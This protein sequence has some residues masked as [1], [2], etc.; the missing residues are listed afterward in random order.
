MSII[1][2]GNKIIVDCNC[3]CE[4]KFVS[5]HKIDNCSLFIDMGLTGFDSL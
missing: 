5:L 4:L 2:Q 1:E 3:N